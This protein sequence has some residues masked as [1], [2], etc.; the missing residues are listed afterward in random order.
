MC[1]GCFDGFP[2]RFYGYLFR[3]SYCGFYG[4]GVVFDVMRDVRSTMCL[5][6]SKHSTKSHGNGDLSLAGDGNCM[7]HDVIVLVTLDLSS[8]VTYGEI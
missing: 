6:K 1:I 4:E 8:C 2:Y 3:E 5:I 7:N